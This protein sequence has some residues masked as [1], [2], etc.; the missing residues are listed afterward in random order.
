MYKA[1]RSFAFGSG[2]VQPFCREMDAHYKDTLHHVFNGDNI[3]QP[4]CGRKVFQLAYC[5]FIHAMSGG[6]QPRPHYNP[7]KRGTIASSGCTRIV[8]DGTVLG[9]PVRYLRYV[10]CKFLIR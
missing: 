5:S 7:E 1:L 4:F 6:L 3:I 9:I 10:H 2:S 8:C